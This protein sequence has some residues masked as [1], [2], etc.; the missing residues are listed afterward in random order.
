MSR[1]DSPL[2]RVPDAVYVDT[3]EMTPDEVIARLL[4]DVEARIEGEPGQ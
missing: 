1:E 4:S 2:V 3:T